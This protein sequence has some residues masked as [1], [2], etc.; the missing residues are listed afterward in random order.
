MDGFQPLFWG[1]ARAEGHHALPAFLSGIRHMSC[2]ALLPCVPCLPCA[3]GLQE[4][5]L[6]QH[7]SFVQ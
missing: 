3:F 7:D 4:S 2:G 6:A 5:T 1:S